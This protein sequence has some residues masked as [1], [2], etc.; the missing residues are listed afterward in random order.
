[1][2]NFQ[3][4]P[5]SEEMPPHLTEVVEVFEHNAGRIS[6]A[7]NTRLVSNKVLARLRPDLIAC[8]Y[9][10]EVDKTRSGRISVPV[11]FGRNGKPTKTFD[12]DAWNAEVRTVIEVEAGRAVSNN[13]FLKDLFQ[14]S[15]MKDVDYLV[16]AVKNVYQRT[17]KDFETVCTFMETLYASNRLRLPLSGI[18][19]LGY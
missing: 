4:Y 18:L 16:V 1:M 17:Q 19:V 11:L 7:R 8:G 15:M 14:A 13:Q 6:S 10:V 3:Y 5:R 9:R 2:I 12:A